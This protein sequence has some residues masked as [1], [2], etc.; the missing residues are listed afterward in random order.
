M[1]GARHTP[2]PWSVKASGVEAL[3]VV[4]SAGETVC[5]LPANVIPQPAER[6]AN[7]NLIASAPAMLAALRRAADQF[8]FYERQ[9]RA[10]G[11]PE[12]DAKA[13]VNAQM[14]AMCLAAIAKA[15]GRS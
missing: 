11:T 14:T 3:R 7:A 10:K 5:G 8:V 6:H 1:S 2:A 15:E 4:G 9:H 12:A 13:E